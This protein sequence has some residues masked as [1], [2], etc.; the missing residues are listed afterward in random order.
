MPLEI[1]P[2]ITLQDWEFAEQ[3]MRASGPGGQH[4]N[5]VSTAVELRFFAD[6]SPHLPGPVK[7]RLK[8]LA[9]RRWTNDGSIVI[10]VDATRSQSRNRELAWSRMK[11]L[12]AAALKAPKPRIA[13]KPKASAVRK[14]LD[15]KKARSTVKSLR[16]RV[17]DTD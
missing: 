13:T 2:K 10:Q 8:R 9:G 4:V 7:T 11:D 5:K 1:S 12:I 3:F 16:S 14:R 17:T 15:Q 6:A